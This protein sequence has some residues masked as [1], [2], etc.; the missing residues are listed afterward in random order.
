MTIKLTDGNSVVEFIE[1]RDGS[2][3]VV[4]DG[5]VLIATADEADSHLAT[6]EAAGFEHC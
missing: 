4:T 2:Y 1:Q 5:D 6:L 3:L